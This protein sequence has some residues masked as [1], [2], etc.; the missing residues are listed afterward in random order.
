MYEDEVKRIVCFSGGDSSAT[1]AVEV[2]RKYGIRNLIIL[3]HNIHPKYEDQDIKRFKQEVAEYIGVNITYA[4]YGGI[5]D[6]L[7]LPSQ[8]KVCTDAGALTSQNTGA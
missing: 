1:V 6:P 2:A 3:N 5:T 8:F 4:N 7:K